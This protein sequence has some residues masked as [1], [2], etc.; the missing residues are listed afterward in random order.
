MERI[1]VLVLTVKL[2]ENANSIPHRTFNHSVA[3]TESNP[4]TVVRLPQ[5]TATALPTLA[6]PRS[7][8]QPFSRI[9]SSRKFEVETSSSA[10]EIQ[11]PANA[12]LLTDQGV[13]RDPRVPAVQREY[14][15]YFGGMLSN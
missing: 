6:C 14:L 11:I 8:P 3:W 2:I 7:V 12:T 15:S 1:F 9:K 4:N 5:Q 10:N 13:L